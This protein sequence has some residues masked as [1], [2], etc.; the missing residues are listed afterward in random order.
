MQRNIARKKATAT[1]KT[2]NTVCRGQQIQESTL[3][4]RNGQIASEVALT[5]KDDALHGC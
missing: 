2:L 5:Y 3:A 4:I 1:E